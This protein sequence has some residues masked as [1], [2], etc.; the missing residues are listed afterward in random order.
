MGR[1][2]WFVG[3][4]IHMAGRLHAPEGRP[5]INL[6]ADSLTHL[7]NFMKCAFSYQTSKGERI[8]RVRLNSRVALGAKERNPQK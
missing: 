3:P 8:T 4:L 6:D 1:Q 2:H 5:A 7:A